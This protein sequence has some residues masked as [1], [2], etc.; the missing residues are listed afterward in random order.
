MADTAFGSIS[1]GVAPERS[2]QNP[3]NGNQCHRSRTYGYR[4]ECGELC[5]TFRHAGKAHRRAGG[6]EI[7]IECHPWQ[8]DCN[9]RSTSSQRRLPC[10]IFS[11]FAGIPLSAA[12]EKGSVHECVFLVLQIRAGLGRHEQ[13]RLLPSRDTRFQML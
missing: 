1:P 3:R 5:G 4:S 6:F 10:K 12:Q 2:F 13:S 9:P 11:D 7:Q 8:R